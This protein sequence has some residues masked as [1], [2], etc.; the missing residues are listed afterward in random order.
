MYV[1]IFGGGVRFLGGFQDG[2]LEYSFKSKASSNGGALKE[3]RRRRA[4]QWLSKMRK[5]VLPALLQKLV[6]NF[7]L[8]FRREIWKM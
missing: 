1:Y 7:F 3:R 6:G 2:F 8:I 4:E 5:K